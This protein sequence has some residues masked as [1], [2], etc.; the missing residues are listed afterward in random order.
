MTR[1]S[2]LLAD[3]KLSPT[4][5]DR[6]RTYLIAGMAWAAAILTNAAVY[7]LQLGGV[8]FDAARDIYRLNFASQPL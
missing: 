4:K 6:Q 2:E 1:N 7:W 5:H 8:R 3:T